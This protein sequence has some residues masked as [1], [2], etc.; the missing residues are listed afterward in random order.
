[1]KVGVLSDT[2]LKRV[3][4]SFAK[5]LAVH[6]SDVD[7]ILHAGDVVETAVLDHFCSREL[8]LVS[9]NMDSPAIR[10]A[11]PLKRVI[12]LGRFRVGLIHGWG[13]PSGIE[14]RIMQ[15]FDSI[16]VLVYGHTHRATAHLNN[17]LLF[18]NPGSPT[19]KRFAAVNTIGI[20]EIGEQVEP[21]IITL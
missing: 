20:L 7:L 6:F 5:S 4:Q 16:D 17:G 15:E 8:L 1:M 13:A 19:D 12:S 21:T 14:E 10:A 11:A 2:H 3:D 18:F 9:G